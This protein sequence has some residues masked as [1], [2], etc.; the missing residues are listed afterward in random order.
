[1]PTLWRI[2]IFIL[3]SVALCA[4]QPSTKP[5]PMN[6]AREARLKKDIPALMEKAGVPGLSIAVIRGA[7]TV[8]TESF[9]IRNEDT[10]KPV[11]ADTMFNVG[12]LSKPVFAYGVLKLVDGGSSN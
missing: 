12:S 9:G 4:A 2:A 7:K 1:M 11:A 8:W 6:A 3:L 10:K 5:V